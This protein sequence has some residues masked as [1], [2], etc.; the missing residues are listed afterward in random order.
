MLSSW[1]KEMVAKFHILLNILQ[2]PAP[3][4]VV[5]NAENQCKRKYWALLFGKQNP[6]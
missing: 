5:T 6:V 2:P 4:F 3:D 1:P